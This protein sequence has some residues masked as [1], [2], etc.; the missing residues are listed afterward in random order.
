[1]D[2]GKGTSAGDLMELYSVL[3]GQVQNYNSIIWQVPMALVA[4]NFV[5]LDYSTSQNPWA[6]FALVVFN[7]AIIYA[8]YKMT[9]RQRAIIMATKAVEARLGSDYGD[10]IPKFKKR[11]V[12][13][14][15]LLIWVLALLNA[16]LLAYAVLPIL[17]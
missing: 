12:S 2:E 16:A 13:A 15:R 11:G 14:P 10:C 8:F 17:T 7:F 6:L 1:M 3:V 4:A 9:V 5:A